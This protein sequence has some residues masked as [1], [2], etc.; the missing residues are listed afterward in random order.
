MSLQMYQKDRPA[1]HK[2]F[3]ML[4]AVNKKRFASGILL[5]GFEMIETVLASYHY[6][7]V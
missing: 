6:L 4:Y 5:T 3:L 2:P 1:Y 7:S